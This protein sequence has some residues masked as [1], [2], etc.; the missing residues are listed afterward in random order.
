MFHV[1]HPVIVVGGGHAGIEAAV[2]AARLGVPTTLVTLERE[3]IGRMPC[4]P[5][6]GGMAKGH[7]VREVDA[8]G[9]V[10]AWLTDRASIQFKRLNTR[11]GLAVQGSRAQVD[12]FRYALEAQRL[13]R[14]VPGL[15][16]IIDSAT[17]I[18]TD[19]GRIRAVV[20]R[21]H[22]ALPAS[23]LVLAT[24]TFLGG[25]VIVGG[26]SYSAGRSGESAVRG[27]SRSLSG[28][29]LSLTR[30]KTG[31]TPRLLDTTVDWEGLPEQTEDDPEGRFSSC[32]ELPGLER[33]RCRITH[34]NERTHD[35]IRRNLHRAPL[36]DGTIEGVGP[37]YCPSIEDKVVR[38][39]DR[40]HHQLFL[41]PEGLQSR[42]IYPNGL[43]TSLPV[44]VQVEMVHTIRG[45]E[46]AEI[47]RPGYAIEYDFA[48][49]RQLAPSLEVRELPGL[50]LAGQINGTTGYEEAAAQGLMA[51]INAARSVRGDEPLVLGREQAYIGVLVDDLVTRGTDEPYRM[52]TSRAEYRMLLREGNADH[53]LSDL[54]ASIGLLDEGEYRRFRE[55]REQVLRGLEQLEACTLRPG[56]EVAAALQARSID[57][58]RRPTTLRLLLARPGVGLEDLGAWLPESASWSRPVAE[59]VASRVKYAGYIER[60]QRQVERQ[61]RTGNVGLPDDLDFEEVAGLSF[62]IREKL[63]R[64][65]PRTMGQAGRIPG[66]TPAAITALLTHLKVRERGGGSR[67]GAREE[68]AQRGKGK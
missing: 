29:G 48:D 10:T 18:R 40:D 7:L 51:G 2:A 41:E 61:R 14:E 36:Y 12:R 66:V 57:P 62:E 4:N 11:K 32:G 43:S 37:R 33:I 60:Q 23:A 30:M 39:A 16:V 49:P 27:L 35:V 6:I 21:D 65:R 46:R 64:V 13:L 17:G 31:T 9:G 19:G 22:G 56:D 5:A 15:E 50:F 34:T 20:T 42:E 45:L 54:G 68:K 38:F 24:G 67:K 63:T 28:A 47:V 59:E 25:R 8:L 3:W 55:R 53:R 1:E 44:E 26:V 58:I 52:F